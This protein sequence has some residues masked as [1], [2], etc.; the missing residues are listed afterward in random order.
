[1]RVLNVAIRLGETGVA[2]GHVLATVSI[3]LV[4]V[5]AAHLAVG[6]G[7]AGEGG[8]I[9]NVAGDGTAP[10]GLAVTDGVGTR[11]AD[12]GPLGETAWVCSQRAGD[13]D[14]KIV[15]TVN[16]K[17]LGAAI[18]RV[19]RIGGAEIVTGASGLAVHIVQGQRIG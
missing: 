13:G 6:D 9:G 17:G 11:A 16:S 5:G 12:F 14:T 19:V 1:M 4:V 10:Y 8:L 2:R 7:V 15:V 3:A 18:S